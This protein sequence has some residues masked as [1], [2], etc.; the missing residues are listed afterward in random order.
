[1]ICK[2]FSEIVIFWSNKN[3]RTLPWD[4]YDEPYR[5]WA[6]EI[7]LQQTTVKQAENYI[8]RFF[9]R[10]PTLKD[11]ANA[12]EETVLKLW[13]GLGYY[14]RARNLHFTAKYVYNDLDGHFPDN[15]KELL[16]LKGI[17][18]YTA[19][20]IAS[21]CY[22]EP[23][24]VL[25]GNVIRVLSRYFNIKEPVNETSTIKLL[26]TKAQLLLDNDNPASYNQAIMNFGAIQ[27]SVHKPD[28]TNCP[29]NKN[30]GAFKLDTV[31]SIPYKSKKIKKRKR[32]F[33][34]FIINDE[35]HIYFHKREHKDIWRHLWEF[36]MIESDELIS[37]SKLR[38]RLNK[39]WKMR[40]YELMMREEVYKQLLTHQQ[41]HARFHRID[42][43]S[44]GPD[45]LKMYKKVAIGKL[46]D[47]PSPQIITSFLSNNDLSLV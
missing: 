37:L 13:E 38:A 34:Y 10:F 22:N 15:F 6:T 16:K 1:M 35:N 28:C 18:P 47:Y 41:I 44:S 7:M 33:D 14:A 2:G 25:D 3:K 24:A 20:A 12:D 30:C 8:N 23:V 43:K 27:C 17:G 9:Q 45:F 46:R 39:E 21:F 40:N 19:A 5:V 36:P 11:L 31:S 26:R 4:R 29:L 42:L 32:Y